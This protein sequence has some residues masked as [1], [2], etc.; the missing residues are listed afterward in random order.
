MIIQNVLL[1][2]ECTTE[3]LAPLVNGIVNNTLFHSSPHVN[4]MWHKIIHILHVLLV[5][6][7]LNYAP[8]F[9]ISWTETRA[10]RLR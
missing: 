6:L 1:W 8:D 7:L 5:D 10:V 4:Q 9:V 3:M 2:L